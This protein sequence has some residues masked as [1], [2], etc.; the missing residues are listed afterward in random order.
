MLNISPDMCAPPLLGVG[1]VRLDSP[2]SLRFYRFGVNPG[3]AVLRARPDGRFP[4]V[5]IGEGPSASTLVG[6]GPGALFSDAPPGPRCPPEQAASQ[7]PRKCRPRDGSHCPPGNV[8]LGVGGNGARGKCRPRSGG[9]RRPRGPG[10]S[11]DSGPG[12]LVGLGARGKCRPRGRGEMSAS[13]RGEMSASERGEMSAS[14][15]GDLVRLGAGGKCRPR[16]RGEMS[17]S[18]PAGQGP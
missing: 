13:E 3:L 4:S 11:S 14:G 15:P 5:P 8:G 6:K 18:G 1:G 16:G 10:T 2:P 7:A 17:A 9:K 12:G